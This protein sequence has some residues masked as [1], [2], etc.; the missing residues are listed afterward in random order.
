MAPMSTQTM[1]SFLAQGD[2]GGQVV[3]HAR[4]HVC[5]HDHLTKCI[6]QI[7]LESQFTNKVVNLL[8]TITNQKI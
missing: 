7:V 4:K 6:Y 5:H 3:S 1:T 2:A 8:F